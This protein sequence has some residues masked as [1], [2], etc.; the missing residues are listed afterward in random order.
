MASSAGRPKPVTLNPKP[1]AIS[2]IFAQFNCNTIQKMYSIRN[3]EFLGQVKIALKDI[4]RLKHDI[5]EKPDISFTVATE[6]DKPAVRCAY[7]YAYGILHTTVVYADFLKY[8]KG[9]ESVFRGLFSKKVLNICCLAGGPAFEA[10]SL[11][12]AISDFTSEVA[13]GDS[14]LFA[15]IHLTV[16]DVFPQWKF[17][18]EII[19]AELQKFPNLFHSENVRFHPGSESADFLQPFDDG[20]KAKIKDADLVTMV[21]FGSAVEEKS[22]KKP[23]RRLEK[24]VNVSRYFI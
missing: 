10:V 23:P 6:F 16:V 1:S 12:K 3:R 14:T 15:D 11:S 9:Q 18:Q 22:K 8:L 21:R 19:V 5:K 2:A 13:D 17:E 7:V 4:R 20:L 24:V